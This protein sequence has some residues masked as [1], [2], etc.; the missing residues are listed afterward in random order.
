MK[1]IFLLLTVFFVG[2][3]AH[4]QF[5]K[6]KMYLGASLS[7]LDLSY[8]GLSKLN[9]TAQAKVGYMIEDNWMVMAQAGI[10]RVGG[11]NSST[12]LSA[13]VGGRYYI[14]QNGLFL[15]ANANL[16]H[17]S[18][19]YNDFVPAVEVGYAFFVS[20]TVTIEPSVYYRQ[21][22]KSHSDYSTIGLNIGVGIYL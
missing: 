2:M 10:Q 3:S 9:L 19:S 17:A 5:E 11:E 13:G 8:S 6:D 12:A 15:G 7:G 20:K 4:A 22:F 14:V 16:V 1:K 21:S 18:K